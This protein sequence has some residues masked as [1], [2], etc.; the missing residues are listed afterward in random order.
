MAFLKVADF[1]DRIEVVVFPKLFVE[2]KA[3]LV[4]DKCVAIKG[5]ISNRNGEISL[6]A[7]AVKE[8]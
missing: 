2:S 5:R 6:I 8:L 7:E 4:A 3:L 1:A